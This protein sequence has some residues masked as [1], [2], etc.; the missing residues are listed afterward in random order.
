MA[1]P[2]QLTQIAFAGG[3]D[4][5]QRAEVLD[6]SAAFVTVEN[7]RQPQRGVFDK[8]LGYASLA[9]DAI[10]SFFQI[11]GVVG[12]GGRVVYDGRSA[13]VIDSAGGPVQDSGAMVF[14]W[15]DDANVWNDCG[16]VTECTA[17]LIDMPSMGTGTKHAADIVACNGYLVT[18][19][20]DLNAVS[21]VSQGF[22][23]TVVEADTGRIVHGPVA[24]DVSSTAK[25]PLLATYGNVVFA[26]WLESTG[27][28]WTSYITLTSGATISTGWSTALASVSG[29]ST[30][31]PF[32][33]SSVSD[34]IL[35]AYAAPGGGASRVS[36][37]A[38]N[39]SGVPQTTTVNTSS[40]TPTAV[41]ISA[42]TG[43]TAWVA[44]NETT[45]VKVQ[46]LNPTTLSSVIATTATCITTA[47]NS[48][49]VRVAYSG[50]TSAAGRVWAVESSGALAT[51][52]R[53]F[54]T[55]AG[56]V[57]ASGATTPSYN[58]AIVSRPFGRGE[59]SRTGDIEGPMFFAQWVPDAATN[60]QGVSILGSDSVGGGQGMAVRPV[61]SAVQWGLSG[62]E[63]DWSNRCGIPAIGQK[64]YT[65]TTYKKSAVAEGVAIVVYDFASSAR[66]APVREGQ[67]LYLSGGI[68]SS[69]DG[70]RVAEV[71]FLVK[72]QLPTWSAGGTGITL[73]NGRRYVAVYEEV[74]ANGTWHQSGIS[75]PSTSTG[76]QTNKTITVQTTHL[77]ITSRFIGAIG[78]AVGL[79]TSNTRVAYYATLDSNSGSPPYYRLGETKTQ[80]E[81]T[82]VTF[83]DNVSDAT[84]ATRQKLYAP[85]LPGVTVG[86]SSGTVGAPQ[87]RRA[88]VGMNHIVSYNN[89]LVGAAGSTVYWSGQ[90]V[91]G[92]GRWFNPIFQQPVGSGSIT[93]IAAQDGALYVFTDSDIYIMTGDAP[94]DNGVGGLGAPRRLAVDVGCIEPRSV[95]VTALGIFFQSRRGIEILTRAQS[96]E[97][98]GE[99]VEVT[100]AA[101]PVITGA[102]L[103]S[104]ASLVRFAC[105]QSETDAQ[106][107]ATGVDLVFDLTLKTWVSVDKVTV[108]DQDASKAAQ[109][110]A[111]VK[112]GG[113]M[114]YA[115]L[116]FGGKLYYER[117]TSDASAYLD[118][119]TWVAR[120][121]VTGWF[122]TSGIQGTQ[123]MNRAL[124]LA[125]KETRSNISI[126]AA[127]DYSDTY[128]AAATWAA[129]T[130]DT[131]SSGI[132]RVQ[133]EHRLDDEAEG[134]AVRLL[135]TEATP[136]GG[137]VGSG[138]GAVWIAL[139]LEGV[140][141]PGAAKLPEACT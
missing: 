43:D 100:L 13:V 113:V 115:R 108:D 52:G 116:D 86:S 50:T 80:A 11:Y 69:F 33:V 137:T 27:D 25:W 139:T 126:S 51:H 106:V 131:I 123:H 38:V 10:H 118:G 30:T 132:G 55:S 136:T 87:D 124:L 85:N 2:P 79:S 31:V 125:K 105:A 93:A 24:I 49:I 42:K 20:A 95:V 133:L 92:E 57:S 45:S 67:D 53:S 14:A 5:A 94:A 8:R 32:G 3:I 21:G 7:V 114:R 46:G 127:Y 101:N 58:V 68:L 6:P 130:I 61:G 78:V 88:P 47:T 90:L 17:E 36:V 70:Y 107:S 16:R 138:R 54:T 22:Y 19:V 41:D 84:L 119:T 140:P 59:E 39:T 111:M 9:V 65:L 99:Q 141:R 71:G 122:K 28:I 40:V 135:I 103:D 91:Q 44:W 98:I 26:V 104:Q 82:N 62:A 129:N 18:L 120:R 73:T 48:T 1:T 128:E 66:W 89:M 64:R 12:Q 37:A 109:S 134:Q 76:A 29:S 56:A 110:V 35:I 102:A 15:S 34:R 117:Q 97:Y 72:P 83:A 74:D 4:E 23:A 63:G 81:A 77:S 96:V 121:V 112:I 75:D 60:P